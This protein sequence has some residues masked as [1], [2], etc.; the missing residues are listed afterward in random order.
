MK[1]ET[2]EYIEDKK[3]DS[4]LR[5]NDEDQ[6]TVECRR[7]SAALPHAGNVYS[8]ALQQEPAGQLFSSMRA[9]SVTTASTV[10]SAMS[11]LSLCSQ[12]ACACHG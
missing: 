3:L 9:A 12:R 2:Y 8:R 1:G 10:T 6:A 5:G 7:A 4:R 11:P